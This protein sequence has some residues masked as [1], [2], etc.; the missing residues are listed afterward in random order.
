MFAA[1]GRDCKRVGGHVG[2]RQKGEE[3]SL[4]GGCV[5]IK[6]YHTGHRAGGNRDVRGRVPGNPK[7]DLSRVDRRIPETVRAQRRLGG[8]VDGEASEPSIAIPRKRRT[9]VR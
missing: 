4:A 5:A 9:H 3:Q 6:H 7:I 2:R 1:T 8:A